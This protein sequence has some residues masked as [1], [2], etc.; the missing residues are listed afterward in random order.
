MTG[1]PHDHQAQVAAFG[2]CPICVREERPTAA[3]LDDHGAVEA[4][5]AFCPEAVK[6][7]DPKTHR[8]VSGWSV[9]RGRTGGTNTLRLRREHGQY[10]H[11]ECVDKAKSGHLAQPELPELSTET[12]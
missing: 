11:G 6:L 2:V 7:N 1:R 12:F 9:Y 10:A 5:C 8:L 3:R 4:P